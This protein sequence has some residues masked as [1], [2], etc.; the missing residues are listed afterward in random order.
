MAGG[1]LQAPA[2]AEEEEEEEEAAHENWF[3]IP[4]T[5]GLLKQQV[6]ARRSEFETGGAWAMARVQR[7][8]R[9]VVVEIWEMA[10]LGRR[11]SRRAEKEKG[12]ACGIH[13]NFITTIAAAGLAIL[14]KTAFQECCCMMDRAEDFFVRR[15]SSDFLQALPT[16]SPTSTYSCYCH[17]MGL[18]EQVWA[19][20]NVIR[21][22]W[23]FL[24]V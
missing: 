3:V 23:N 18:L 4:R 13:V 12:N 8:G 21:F 9:G 11:R 19:F 22:F 1:S 24:R 20:A 5:L 6:V 10:R 17:W 16:P 15:P 7:R 2:I 14:C